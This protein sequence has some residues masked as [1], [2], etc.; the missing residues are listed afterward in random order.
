[1][2]R[3]A[4]RSLERF[5]DRWIYGSTLPRLTFGYSVESSPSGQEVVLRFEQLGDLFDVPVTVTLQS[6]DR[7]SVDV[8]VPI[9]ERTVD[10]RVRFDGSLR[11]VAIS[12]DDGTIAE[13]SKAP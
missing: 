2:E 5:F 1:M 11:S 6:H 9:T 8:V 7:R 3:E 13:V 12:R 4:G 10:K